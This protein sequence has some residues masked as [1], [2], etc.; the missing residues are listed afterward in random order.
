MNYR[1]SSGL[2]GDRLVEIRDV[3][4]NLQLVPRIRGHQTIG[5]LSQRNAPTVFLLLTTLR[6]DT[7]SSSSGSLSSAKAFTAGARAALCDEP[8]RLGCAEDLRRFGY[9]RVMYLLTR[10]P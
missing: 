9:N 7:S 1:P 3:L 4:V 8:P 6:T 5:A 2:I 10:G